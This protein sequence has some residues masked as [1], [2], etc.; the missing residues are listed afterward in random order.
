MKKRKFEI[1]ATP[2]QGKPRTVMV[3]GLVFDDDATIG[4]HPRLRHDPSKDEYRVEDRGWWMITHIPSGRHLNWQTSLKKDQ[5]AALAKKYIELG[6]GGVTATD[7][8]GALQGFEALGADVVVAQV[9]RLWGPMGDGKRPTPK[10]ITS[11][12]RQITNGPRV[13]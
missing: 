13:R 7:H 1:A 5:A 6:W 11:R 9:N 10:Q 4:I 3:D 2:V 12:I 8:D